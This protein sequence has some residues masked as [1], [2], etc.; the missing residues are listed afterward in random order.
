MRNGVA[1]RHEGGHA[2]GVVEERLTGGAQLPLILATTA[3]VASASTAA[4]G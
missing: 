3:A 2:R 4:T 1:Q